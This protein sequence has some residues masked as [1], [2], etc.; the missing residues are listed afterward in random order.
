[1]VAAV[2][3][4]LSH[5]KKWIY[6]S[7]HP[8]GRL[9]HRADVRSAVHDLGH[10]RHAVSAPRRPSMPPPSRSA[11]STEMSLKAFH[12]LFIALSVI[13]AAFFAAWAVGQF[14]LEHEIV[15]VAAGALGVA[16]GGGL[17]VYG[18]AFQRKTRG[19]YAHASRSCSRAM[20][21][22][23]PRAALACPVCF[24]QS[25]SPLAKAMN[26]GILAMLG[27]VVAVLAGFASFFVHLNRRARL[28]GAGDACRAHGASRLPR[29][30]TPGGDRS[31]LNFL[32]L[33]PQASTHA[34]EIDHM[35]VLVHWLMVV[36]FVGWGAFFVF[37]LF[38]FRKGANPTARL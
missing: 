33:P 22:A 38:R 19:M 20:L 30:P 4:H 11:W 10:D 9:L 8:D 32:G 14:R 7:L 26:M 16:A 3:M 21:L 6:G 27:V 15:Y 18:T 25:D 12:L 17:V 23:V 5:E 29:Q 36:L 13:L 35:T 2:F 28:A 34:A 31:M 1:M 24:G 37:V